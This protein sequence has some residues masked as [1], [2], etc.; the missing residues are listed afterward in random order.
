MSHTLLVFALNKNG[1]YLEFNYNC[2]SILNNAY[3]SLESKQSLNLDDLYES[4]FISQLLFY[5]V[6]QKFCMSLVLIKTFQMIIKSHL[7]LINK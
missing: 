7:F 2:F 4:Q 3:L 5:F 6:Y 1:L